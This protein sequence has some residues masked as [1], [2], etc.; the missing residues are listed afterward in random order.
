MRFVK[1]LLRTWA[2][3]GLAACVLALASPG[4]VLAQKGAKPAYVVRALAP[5]E[6]TAFDIQSYADFSEV[7]GQTERECAMTTDF[8]RHLAQIPP[9]TTSSMPPSREVAASSWPDGAVNRE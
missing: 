3:L 2:L 9:S 5:T 4:Q 1:T 7:V 6:G 8:A